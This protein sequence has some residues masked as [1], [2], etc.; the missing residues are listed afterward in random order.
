MN[1][2]IGGLAVLLLSGPA[3]AAID[4]TVTNRTSGKPQPGISV[5]LIRLGRGMEM[6][7]TVKTDAQGRFSFPVEAEAQMPYLVQ[8]FHEG[9]SYSKMIQPG[10]PT[11]GLSV[12]VFDVS[13]KA[14]EV[15]TSEHI[16]FI[17]P[18]QAG[19]QINEIMA[20]RNQG[21]VTFNDPSGTVRFWV[22]AGAGDQVR[23]S[24]STGAGVPITREAQKTSR[25]NVWSVA[26]PIKPGETRLN[27]T[28]VLPAAT[29]F[30]SRTLHFGNLRVVAPHG[31]QLSG[32][33]LTSL[34]TEPQTQATIYA[35]KGPEFK[36]EISGTPV[37]ATA[38]AAAADASG[39]ED[40]GGSIEQKLPFLYN[41]LSLILA[42]AG[43]I[44]FVGFVL[45]YRKQAGHAPPV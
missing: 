23:V 5:N 33:G 13:A 1:K 18:G 9:V 30:E 17:E 6:A 42:L 10:T 31:V 41:R 35:A 3:F 32:A 22:P 20:I 27:I 26:Y 37:A 16:I 11:T 19:L 44:L 28:Y 45:L 34:G 43:G 29:T 38:P 4:G 7:S 36:V 25:E 15:E 21:N 40:P 14:S 2:L 24:F 8:A 12:D 39:G